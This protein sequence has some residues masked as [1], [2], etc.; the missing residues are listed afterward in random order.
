MIFKELI[1]YY[2]YLS[3]QTFVD[4]LLY[5]RHC[6]PDEVFDIGQNQVVVIPPLFEDYAL[7]I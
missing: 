2:I 6:V 4:L 1:Y 7:P 5:Q 3:H